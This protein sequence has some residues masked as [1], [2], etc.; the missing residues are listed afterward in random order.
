MK[1]LLVGLVRRQ[2]MAALVA[3]AAVGP[4]PHAVAGPRLPVPS[5]EQRRQSSAKIREIFDQDAVRATN[6]AAK[7]KLAAE[8][9]THAG[10]SSE[11]PDQY[12]LLDAA[13]Q[14]ATDA[15]D[16]ETAIKAV[17]LLGQA[18]DVDAT[19]LKAGVLDKLAAKAPP[20]S[21][22]LVIDALL[23]TSDGKLS[24]DDV[25]QAEDLAQKAVAAARRS[26][27]RG[28][29]KKAADQLTNIRERKK[30]LAQ[31][32]PFLDRLAIDPNDREAALELGVIRCFQQD[33][34]PSG[35]AL[36]ARGS[37]PALARLARLDLEQG[38]DGDLR[39]ELGDAWWEYG[40]SQKAPMKGGALS[41]AVAHYSAVL[42][43]LKGLDRTRVEK[44]IAAAVAQTPGG[45]KASRSAIAKTP[46]LLFWFDASAK[47]SVVGQRGNA[48]GADVPINLES[49]ADLGPEHKSG[50]QADAAKQPSWDRSAFGGRGGLDFDGK[51]LLEVNAPCGNEG[52]LFLVCEPRTLSNMRVLGN[53]PKFGQSVGLSFRADGQLWME[54]SESTSQYC[55]AKSPPAAYK[56][57]QT[58][59]VCGSWGRQVDLFVNGKPAAEPQQL[60]WKVR[61]DNPWG[62]GN[63]NLKAGSEYFVGKVGEVVAFDRQL[64]PE[65]IR[66]I[67]GELLAKWGVR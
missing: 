2:A 25:E 7:A 63:A 54:V 21:L 18:Y 57:N 56:A 37:D 47:N 9:L 14:L 42:P 23:E 46:G 19:S 48:A 39:L 3:I 38:E 10:D 22:E 55:V 20:A 30:G 67:A 13:M 52:T 12:V 26:K 45:Q 33:E 50:R 59:V 24:G 6:P 53:H 28:L 11:P 15:G 44:R 27:D 51:R 8:L 17:D 5:A 32:K 4:L 58:L 40:E 65:Q 41:R 64:P 66:T 29:Q 62:I 1:V 36:L 34:W 43:E 49:W 61:F 31:Q 60:G 16:P 35:L